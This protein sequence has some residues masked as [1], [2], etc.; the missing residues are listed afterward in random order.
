ME[1]PSYRNVAEK[2][3][4]ICLS[5]YFTSRVFRSVQ[6]L[7]ER[8]IGNVQSMAN[9]YEML[10]PSVTVCPRS[11]PGEDR[12]PASFPALK[13]LNESDLVKLKFALGSYEKYVHDLILVIPATCDG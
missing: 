13:P 7:R 11:P 9:T 8:A 12:D 4:F 10:Y 6:K 2:F 5:M 3:V 1:L